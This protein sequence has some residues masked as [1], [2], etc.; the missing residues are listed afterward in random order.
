MDLQ[1]NDLW[2]ALALVLVLEGVMPFLLPASYRR[3]MANVA[4]L[5]DGQLR[6]IGLISMALGL[7]VL[8]LVR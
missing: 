4:Q 8:Y 7:L 5:P 6:S 1:W 3:T 2:S